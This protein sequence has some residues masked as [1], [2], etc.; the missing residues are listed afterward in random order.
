MMMTTV[1][2]GVKVVQAFLEAFACEQSGHGIAICALHRFRINL[3]E[4][5]GFRAIQQRNIEAVARPRG[6]VGKLI[7]KV[8]LGDLHPVARRAIDEAAMPC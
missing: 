5:A 7:L 3:V 6:A 2:A 1:D 4:Q 8:R